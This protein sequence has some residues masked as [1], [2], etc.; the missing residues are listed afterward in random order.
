[1]KISKFRLLNFKSIEDIEIQMDAY[2][3]GK[4]YSNLSIMVGIN[5]SGKSSILEGINL[6]YEEL[7]EY[8]FNDYFHKDA[9]DEDYISL[10]AF[11]NPL[12]LK[13]NTEGL[14]NLLHIDALD[15]DKLKIESFLNNTWK[16]EVD[17]GNEYEISISNDFPYSKYS[18]SNEKGISKRD[19]LFEELISSENGKNVFQKLTNN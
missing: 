19:S 6:W 13:W 9:K 10:Q 4:E 11:F 18:Y 17:F 14:I 15:I 8:N 2:G 1:M 7:D 3:N 5:E 12:D 16:S